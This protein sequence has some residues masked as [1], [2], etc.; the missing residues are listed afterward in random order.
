MVVTILRERN[1]TGRSRLA[2]DLAYQ[3]ACAGRSVLLIDAT[4][5]KSSLVWSGNRSKAGIKPRIPALAIIDK[6]LQPELESN[7]SRYED[8]VI[9]IAECDSIASKSALV[10]ARLV[11]IPIQ[12]YASDLA[13]QDKLIERM[14]TARLFNP[15]LR[16]LVVLVYADNKPSILNLKNAR[17]FVMKMPSA[18]LA[19]TIVRDP[20]AG[21]RLFDD[22]LSLCE[23]A[24]DNTAIADLSSF[25]HEVFAD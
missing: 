6:G 3:C 19:N 24:L 20:A 12:P 9:D 2:A 18:R 1:G 23:D 11:V 22:G 16:V 21:R 15:R 8:I 14:T 7:I 4:P 10:A 25:Y 5:D 13:Y 17:D